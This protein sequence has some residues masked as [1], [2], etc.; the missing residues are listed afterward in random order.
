MRFSLDKIIPLAVFQKN[1]FFTGYEIEH[2]ITERTKGVFQELKN[3]DGEC[4]KLPD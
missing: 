2:L 4:F 1:Q 3:N